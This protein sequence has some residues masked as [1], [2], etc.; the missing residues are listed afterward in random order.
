MLQMQCMPPTMSSNYTLDRFI[1]W[2]GIIS[3]KELLEIMSAED[4]SS[5]PPENYEYL[6]RVKWLGDFTWIEVDG[7]GN[8]KGSTIQTSGDS[9][10]QS[11]SAQD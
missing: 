2:Y 6:A 9:D 3:K 10:Q 1:I 11:D 5:G 7:Q 4:W 8:L